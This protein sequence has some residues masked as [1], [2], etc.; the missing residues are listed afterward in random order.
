[1]K[2]IKFITKDIVLFF[3]EQLINFYGGSIEIRDEN[4]L[5]SALAQPKATFEGKYLHDTLYK[6]SA[7]YG[8]HLCNNHPFIDG[9]KRI[10]FVV[11]D[12]FLQRNNLEIIASE[13]EVYKTMIYL[14]SG[15]LSKEKL[16]L[17]LKKNTSAINKKHF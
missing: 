15:Q 17:W 13:K 11:M 9:T 5:D 16:A 14:A 6:M 1:M 7:A 12:T 3:H 8:Y 4:L 10:A 2:D